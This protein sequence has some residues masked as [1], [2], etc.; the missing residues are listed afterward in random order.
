M[1]VDILNIRAV[2]IVYD[3]GEKQNISSYI[4]RSA[5]LL[6]VGNLIY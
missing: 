5:E 1:I 4:Y 3:Q 2:F 6:T